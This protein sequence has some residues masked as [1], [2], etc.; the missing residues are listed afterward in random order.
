MQQRG[1]VGMGTGLNEGSQFSFR[2]VTQWLGDF[3]FT[4]FRPQ[5]SLSVNGG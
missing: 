4:L 2:R 5:S 3:D 1:V